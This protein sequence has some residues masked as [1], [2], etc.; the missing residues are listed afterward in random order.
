MEHF[1]LIFVSIT[2]IIIYF[3]FNYSA[4]LTVKKNC[5]TVIFFKRIYKILF[6]IGSVNVEYMIAIG[7]QTF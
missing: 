6:Q 2:I 1:F 4:Y 7:C 3:I 5:I